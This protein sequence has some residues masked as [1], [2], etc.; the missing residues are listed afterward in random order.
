MTRR[1]AC[2]IAMFLLACSAPVQEGLTG[3]RITV[4]YD[5]A[6]SIAQ[7]QIRGEVDAALDGGVMM[8]GPETRPPTPA[9]SLNPEG[10][11]LVVLLPDSAGGRPF[12]A[13]VDGLDDS[14]ALIASGAG[15]GHGVGL[16]QT[17]ALGMARGGRKGEAILEH[18]YSGASVERLY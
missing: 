7:I 18:Y 17:G 5:P 14:G 4:T 6:I 9:Q 2:T 16:C 3:V 15:N 10:E 13:R 12:E 8:Y 11:T 1:A